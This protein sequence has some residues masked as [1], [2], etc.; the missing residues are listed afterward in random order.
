MLD[1]NLWVCIVSE[2]LHVGKLASRE[3]TLAGFR[4]GPQSRRRSLDRD[5]LQSLHSRHFWWQL[6]RQQRVDSTYSRA[7]IAGFEHH[8]DR[9]IAKGCC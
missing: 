7:E 2:V 5:R 8:K 9:L 1:E 6:E 4:H 3:L